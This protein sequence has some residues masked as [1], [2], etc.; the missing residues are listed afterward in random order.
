M[1]PAAKLSDPGQIIQPITILTERF[2]KPPHTKNGGEHMAF[3]PFNLPSIGQEEI[4]EVTSTLRSGWLT[5]GPKT[6]QFEG[7]FKHYVQAPYALAV[8]SATS[9]LHLA[10]AA[11][12]LGSG[13]EV[14]TTPLTFCATINTILQVGATPVLADV[15][16]DGNIDP[17]SI[18]AKVTNRT[19][20]IMPVHLGGLPCDMDAIWKLA[21]KHNLFVIEDA[22]HAIGSH[23]KGHP[24]GAAERESGYRSDAV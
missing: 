22:A 10:L 24:I 6:A 3:I 23:Y 12:N 14:I 5:T 17:A 9:G 15:G 11:L 20:A 21:R 13:D 1:E 18:A 4:D 19:R 8:K 16:A 7:E 2:N